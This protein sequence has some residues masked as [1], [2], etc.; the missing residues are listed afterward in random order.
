MDQV[1]VRAVYLRSCPG[2]RRA[3]SAW[4]PDD[5]WPARC[6]VAPAP[7]SQAPAAA[8]GPGTTA[9]KRN[10][11]IIK[12]CRA[13][14][15]SVWVTFVNDNLKFVLNKKRNWLKTQQ[16]LM[17]QHISDSWLKGSV[18]HK[19]SNITL[20][21]RE[22]SYLSSRVAVMVLVLLPQGELLWISFFN[23]LVRHLFTHTLEHK[24]IKTLKMYVTPLL[25]VCVCL[26]YD[27]SEDITASISLRIFH[28]S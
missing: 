17:C 23:H 9:E 24:V 1:S 22:G 15:C 10:T 28:C 13:W 21:D 16:A 26:F 3:S 27:V 4:Q 2:S 20:K 12:C 5:R 25:C 6:P 8:P 11:H 14:L 7:W 19:R 18:I